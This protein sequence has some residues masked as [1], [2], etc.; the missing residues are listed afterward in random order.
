MLTAKS[1]EQ[2]RPDTPS[3]PQRS[4]TER[5]RTA[6]SSLR[7]HLSSATKKHKRASLHNMVSP[8]NAGDEGN[9]DVARASGDTY[10]SAEVT[11]SRRTSL[12]DSFRSLGHRT[13]TKRPTF[14]EPHQEPIDE[15]V[16][17]Q[18][19]S[20]SKPIDIPSAP[21]VLSLD[22]G[23]AG[24]DA[25]MLEA[26]NGQDE[27]GLLTDPDNITSGIPPNSTQVA[28]TLPEWQLRRH[29]DFKCAPSFC[30]DSI[31]DNKDDQLCSTPMPGKLQE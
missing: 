19:S 7:M 1:S 28:F 14:A 31:H 29:E 27:F 10:R 26:G 12:A 15:C 18:S 20:P 17:L 21:P 24:F 4:E 11:H 30:H 23:P 8:S 9:E 3:T 16:A 2:K 5:R 13:S 25:P 22:L 6:A